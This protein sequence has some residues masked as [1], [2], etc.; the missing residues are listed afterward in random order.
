M[1]EKTP[2]PKSRRGVFNL[3]RIIRYY[4]LR[5][6][7]L[8]DTPQKIAWGMFLGVF[9]GVTPTVPFHIVSTLF[10][11]P[12]LRVS[13]VA[14]FIGLNVMNPITI[15]PM[16]YAAYKVGAAFLFRE[17]ALNFPETLS[18]T[19]MLDL[20]WRGGLA[21]QLGGLIL[22]LPSA[23][24]SYLLTLWVVKRLRRAKILKLYETASVHPISQNRS[25][26]PGTET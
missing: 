25:P 11:A 22:A 5:F 4:W 6:K 8:Q 23:L 13:P 17:A 1:K 14:A 15:A 21:L 16:Y 24:M 19:S 10:L 20:L 7:R 12:L 2:P 3:K 18:L 9:I 26:T